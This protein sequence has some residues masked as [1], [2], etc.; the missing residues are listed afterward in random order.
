MAASGSDLRGYPAFRCLY[1]GGVTAVYQQNWNMLRALTQDATSDT[2]YGRLPKGIWSSG[3]VGNFTRY[4]YS[5]S[6]RPPLSGSV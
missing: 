2:G 6:S 5:T 3:P 1:A 4:W